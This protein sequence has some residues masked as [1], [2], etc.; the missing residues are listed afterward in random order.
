[1]VGRGWR[2]WDEMVGDNASGIHDPLLGSRLHGQSYGGTSWEC[3]DNTFNLD[4][5]QDAVMHTG[6][7]EAMDDGVGTIGPNK[8]QENVCVDHEKRHFF[9]TD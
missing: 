6:S 1:M 9:N 8:C 2:M 4:P 5:V 3:Y 7:Y